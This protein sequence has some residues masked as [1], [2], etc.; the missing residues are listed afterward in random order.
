M[1]PY[2]LPIQD[3]IGY[4]TLVFYLQRWHEKIT[5]TEA[6]PPVVRTLNTQRYS[7]TDLAN[8][9]I[10]KEDVAEETHHEQVSGIRSF[11]LYC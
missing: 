10:D 9:E 5:E 1:V 8:E 11:D 3:R 7:R 2:F 6:A 4:C